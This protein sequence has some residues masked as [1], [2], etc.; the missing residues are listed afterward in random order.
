VASN[1]LARRARWVIAAVLVAVGCTLI[2]AAPGQAAPNLTI[3]QVKAQVA[4]L[5][6]E[7][8]IA[9]EK[10][11]TADVKVQQGR[12]HLAQVQRQLAQQKTRLDRLSAQMGAYA[13]A[14][15]AN[16]GIDP[17]VQLMLSDNPGDFLSAAASL[18]QVARMQDSTFRQARAAALQMAQTQREVDQQLAQL[19]T[20]KQEAD[21]NR[22]QVNAKLAQAK[23]L[24]SK[25]TAAQQR[26]LAAQQQAARSVT[27]SH[28][29]YSP[30]SSSGTST[31]GSG[32]YHAPAGSG[33][34][35]IAV[36]YAMA[37]VGKAYVYGGTG[38]YGYD[39]SGLTM[40]AW[41]QAGVSLPHSASAQYAMTPRVAISD[42]QP[43]DLLFFYS[44]IHHVGMYIGGG[45]FV[46]AENPSV[47]V[48]VQPLAGYWS[49]V[50]V[51]AGRV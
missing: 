42:L 33:R 14:M 5:Q 23:A 24:L 37:Q 2:P 36:A 27:V 31:G 49:T 12:Q 20:L 34:G 32:G 19:Q 21:S 17:S 8:E 40:M 22:A 6:N 44:D 7:A 43:G 18:D 4:Q 50:Y 30:A 48:R 9:N 35:A 28:A 46:N 15:Y 45:M 10:A 11:N 3:D 26:R 13:A 51:G 39:C 16:G 29:S 47:G 25:L 1:H 41:A 38:P